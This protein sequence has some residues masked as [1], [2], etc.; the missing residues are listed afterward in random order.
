[1][2]GARETER[3]NVSGPTEREREWDKREREGVSE[4]GN[5]DREREEDE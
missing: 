4:L 5:R 1:M 3:G 2:S